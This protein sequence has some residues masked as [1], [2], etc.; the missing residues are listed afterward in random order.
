MK[1]ALVITHVAHE[2]L[3]TF[4]RPLERGF[5]VERLDIHRG[6]ALPPR[7]DGFDALI[8]MGGPMGVYEEEKYPFI[9]KELRLIE[10]A[11]KERVPVLGVCLGAQLLARASGA[12]V[13]KGDAREIGWHRVALEDEAASDRLF[14]GFPDEFTVFQWHGDTFDVPPGGVR[15]ASSGLFPNQVVKVG[16]NAYGVQFHFEVTEAMVR[17][18]L[19]LNSAEVAE[20]RVDAGA[21]LNEMPSVIGEVNRLGNMLFSRFIR[22][23]EKW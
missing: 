6:A 12:R 1:R 8:V 17:E 16:P 4:R 14:M 19:A 23:A 5:I 15:L 10:S 7:I 9:K 18:W 11:L 21:V 22:M 2:G 13:Y 20:A 3:G